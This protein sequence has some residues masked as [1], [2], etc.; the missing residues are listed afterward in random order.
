MNVH[1]N[2]TPPNSNK[3]NKT[4]EVKIPANLTIGYLITWSGRNPYGPFYAG[5]VSK[6]IDDVNNDPSIL[7]RTKLNFIWGDSMC[8]PAQA[9]SEAVDMYHRKVNVIIGQMFDYSKIFLT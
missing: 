4:K 2:N 3:N 7:N 5:A 6:S 1:A 9:V 8:D